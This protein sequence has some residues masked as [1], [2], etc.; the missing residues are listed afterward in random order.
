MPPHGGSQGFSLALEDAVVLS[1]IFEKEG[2]DD[3]ERVFT[4]FEEIRKPRV[5]KIY[6]QANKN[7]GGIKDIGW[8]ANM[9]REFFMWIYLIFFAK[10]LEESYMYD[11]YKV[12][13]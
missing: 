9:V 11:A 13:I 12:E 1:L 3:L 10:S 6:L 4:R 2:L 7:W 8:F 5:D